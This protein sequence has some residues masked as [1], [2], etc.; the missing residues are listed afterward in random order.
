MK[1]E[2]VSV[3]LIIALLSETKGKG[4]AQPWLIPLTVGSGIP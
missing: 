3:S 1:K 4:T 2:T